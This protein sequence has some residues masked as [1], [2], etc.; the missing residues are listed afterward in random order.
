[1]DSCTNDEVEINGAF[2]RKEHA[3]PVREEGGVIIYEHVI[4]IPLRFASGAE[5]PEHL[6]IEAPHPIRD[7][8]V[9]ELMNEQKGAKIICSVCKTTADEDLGLEYDV[10]RKTSLDV[11]RV[12]AR[13]QRF[14]QIKALG[15]LEKRKQKEAPENVAVSDKKAKGKKQ[16]R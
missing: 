7:I 9:G 16:G 5:Y 10:H 2:E 11:E 14:Q 6:H 15:P 8:T 3:E 4:K 13:I 12:R 1:L